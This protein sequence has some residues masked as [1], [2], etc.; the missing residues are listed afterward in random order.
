MGEG[1][2]RVGKEGTQLFGLSRM[3]KE[4][5]KASGGLIGPTPELGRREMIGAW[6]RFL[7]AS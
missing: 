7:H 4:A 5:Q 2:E 3:Q 6:Q 1:Q